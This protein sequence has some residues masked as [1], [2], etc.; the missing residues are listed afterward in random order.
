MKVTDLLELVFKWV[1]VSSFVL[2]VMVLV[3]VLTSGVFQDPVVPLDVL[4]CTNN[5]LKE[6]PDT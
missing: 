2:H 6:L 4:A 3:L 1:T 5:P